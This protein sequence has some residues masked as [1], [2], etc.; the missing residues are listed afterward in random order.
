M[1]IC[2]VLCTSIQGI[3]ALLMEAPSA[4][5]DSSAKYEHTSK[6]TL[7][8]QKVFLY[9]LYERSNNFGVIIKKSILILVGGSLSKE[10]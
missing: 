2:Q 10:D 7:A 1:F 8:S 5:E 6:F 3:Y 4:K 9:I